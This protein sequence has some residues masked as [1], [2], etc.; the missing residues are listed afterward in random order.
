MVSPL[1]FAD[2]KITKIEK[3]IESYNIILNNEIKILNILF[4]N[5][6][7]EFPQYKGKNK[8]YQQ[9]SVLKELLEVIY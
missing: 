7:L 4:K 1:L 6:H 9:F 3:N 5:N 8:T 2:M